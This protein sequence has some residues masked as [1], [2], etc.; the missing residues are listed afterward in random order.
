MYVIHNRIVC[1]VFEINAKW[2]GQK[3]SLRVDA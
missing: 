3:V 1:I 2:V